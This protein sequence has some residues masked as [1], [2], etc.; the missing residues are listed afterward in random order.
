MVL[1]DQLHHGLLNPTIKTNSLYPGFFRLKSSRLVKSQFSS[2]LCKSQSSNAVL[3]NSPCLDSQYKVEELVGVGS[4]GRVH[5][6][7]HRESK[8]VVAIKHLLKNRNKIP[9]EK[10][11]DKLRREVDI[12][13]KLDCHNIAKLHDYIEDS[14]SVFMVLDYCEGGDLLQHLENNGPM[15]ETD[16]LAVA[17]ESLDFIHSCHQKGIY[18]GDI[19]PANFCFTR[20]NIL[21]C[22]R[23]SQNLQPWL[24]AIDFGCSQYCTGNQRLVKRAGTPVFMAPEIL[25]RNYSLEADMWSLGIMLYQLYTGK[26]PYWAEDI[27][28]KS[29]SLDEVFSAVSNKP[30]QFDSASWRVISSEGL[31]FIRCCLTRDPA[32]RITSTEALS[33]NWIRQSANSCQGLGSLL[34]LHINALK[35]SMAKSAAAVAANTK[36]GAMPNL[37]LN[38][39]NT[40]P[41][42]IMDSNLP[43]GIEGNSNKSQQLPSS[44]NP[45]TARQVMHPAVA[46]VPFTAPI[47]TPAPL[48]AAA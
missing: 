21:S 17:K 6:G 34:S 23:H 18:H 36:S 43:N 37:S 11:L 9:I 12:M 4:F 40:T 48:P 26:F 30:I 32:L 47:T 22:H 20:K 2:V 15:L 46:G 39:I 10:T 33:H 27:G 31:D 16:L 8:Q 42:G 24:K 45:F 14:E 28:A 44:F 19:K 41:A 1:S 29:I 35:K 3:P 25:S 7:V 5:K 38:N 13:K